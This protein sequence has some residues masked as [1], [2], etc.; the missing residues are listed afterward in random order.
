MNTHLR[1]LVE[2]VASWIA[3][4]PPS[5]SQSINSSSVSNANSSR[6]AFPFELLGSKKV[7]DWSCAFP[8]DFSDRSALMRR[9]FPTLNI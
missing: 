9:L 6:K 4:R 8:D 3:T 7:A 2:F 5:L 1:S